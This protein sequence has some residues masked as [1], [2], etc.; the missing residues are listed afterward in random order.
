MCRRFLDQYVSLVFIAYSGG[1]NL[2]NV[3]YDDTKPN[4]WVGGARKYTLAFWNGF[5]SKA[6][7]LILESP[8]RERKGG[9]RLAA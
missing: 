9:G 4:Y 6:D 2:L 7:I 5:S 3:I 8:T 1:Y